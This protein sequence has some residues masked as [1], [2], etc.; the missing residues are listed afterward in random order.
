MKEAARDPTSLMVRGPLVAG[1]G[2]TAAWIDAARK[3]RDAGVTHI[4]VTVLPDV[5]AEQGLSRV[6]EARAAV[7]EALA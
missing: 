7:A 4:N 6:I 5:P 1:D 2:G 3:M